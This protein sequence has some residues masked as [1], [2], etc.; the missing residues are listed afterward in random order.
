MI[1]SKMQDT[2]FRMQDAELRLTHESL[3]EA[4]IVDL[5]EGLN[6]FWTVNFC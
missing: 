1:D 5:E 2:G 4:C 3:S 6:N